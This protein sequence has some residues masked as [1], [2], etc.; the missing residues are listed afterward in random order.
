V[1]KQFRHDGDKLRSAARVPLCAPPPPQTYVIPSGAD[2][3]LNLDETL[4]PEL[5]R[6]HGGYDTAAV[7]KWHLGFMNWCVPTIADVGTVPAA[8]P[9]RVRPA[10]IPASAQRDD[11]CLVPPAT[12]RGDESCWSLRVSLVGGGGMVARVCCCHQ[13]HDAH[14]P[15]FQLVPRVRTLPWLRVGDVRIGTG[16]HPH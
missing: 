14:L 10:C 9:S 11:L 13:E 8:T 12:A 1:P 6:D 15:R 3:G 5:L 7:G 4:L 16:P 2:Y